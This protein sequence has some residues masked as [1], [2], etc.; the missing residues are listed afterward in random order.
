VSASV[1]PIT[2]RPLMGMSM[3]GVGLTEPISHR[4][5]TCLTSRA[6]KVEQHAAGSST[7]GGPERDRRGPVG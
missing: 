3:L 4:R 2:K 5:H 6:P 7:S 1:K